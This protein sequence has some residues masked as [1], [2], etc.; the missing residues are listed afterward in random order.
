MLLARATR[1]AAPGLSPRACA[2][3]AP[4][5]RSFWGGAFASDV[6]EARA[7]ARRSRIRSFIGGLETMEPTAAERSYEVV[8]SAFTEH[9]QDGSFTSPEHLRLAVDD[10]RLRLADLQ[11]ASSLKLALKSSEPEV[12]SSPASAALAASQPQTPPPQPLDDV[13]VPDVLTDEQQQTVAS[14]HATEAIDALPG[15][16][17]S[18]VDAREPRSGGAPAVEGAGG[19]ITSLPLT[20]ALNAARA[21]S[22]L[23]PWERAGFQ[24]SL[25]RRDIAMVEL[26]AVDEVRQAALMTVVAAQPLLASLLRHSDMLDE[27]ET[28]RLETLLPTLPTAGMC[29]HM[30]MHMHTQCA[31]AC[32]RAACAY[33]WA[34]RPRRLQGRSPYGRQPFVARARS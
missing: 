19:E 26:A 3:S 15:L 17:P 21:L 14:M 6:D 29:N 9:A 32:T 11:I 4:H 7:K 33:A 1:R 8:A 20:D 23:D 31:R 10:A 18:L 24:L 25:E 16:W 22:A 5:Q 34:F 27:A 12:Q 28:K 13:V 2:W 30:H